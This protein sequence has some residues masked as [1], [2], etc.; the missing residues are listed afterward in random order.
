[1]GI[2]FFIFA[3]GLKELRILA[4]MVIFLM[5]VIVAHLPQLL[6]DGKINFPNKLIYKSDQIQ[7]MD[8]IYLMIIP[9]P[10]QIILHTWV[11]YPTT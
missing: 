5:I 2:F 8:F 4:L 3:P 7:F 1:M 11:G 9:I 10:N 6:E